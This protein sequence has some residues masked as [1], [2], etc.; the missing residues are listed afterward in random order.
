MKQGLRGFVRI[1]AGGKPVNIQ[2]SAKTTLRLRVVAVLA[3]KHAQLGQALSSVFMIGAEGL[4]GKRGGLLES[5]V[6]FGRAPAVKKSGS[7]LARTLRQP[8]AVR[9]TLSGFDGLNRS[10]GLFGFAVFFLRQLDVHQP[11][12]G[13]R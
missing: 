10:N 5:S 3:G 8:R 13:A 7:Q 11:N 6:G 9:R 1:G 12:Q 2:R 4:L